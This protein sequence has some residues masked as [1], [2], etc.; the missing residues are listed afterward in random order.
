MLHPSPAIRSL[1]SGIDRTRQLPSAR[2]QILFESQQALQIMR[3]RENINMGKRRTNA[4]RYRPIVF[5]SQKRIQ[6]QQ[7]LYTA[8]CLA[9]LRSQNFRRAGVPTVAQNNKEGVARKHPPTKTSIELSERSA[10][11][12]AAGPLPRPL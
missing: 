8:A 6:P 10:D 3:R 11:P 12:G 9:K 7:L 2:L 1:C 5:Q 4:T